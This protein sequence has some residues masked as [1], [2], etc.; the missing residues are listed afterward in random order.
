MCHFSTRL[1]DDV[2]IW[3]TLGFALVTVLPNIAMS[4]PPD[5]LR[6]RSRVAV[7]GR[8]AQ[9][10]Y[11][12]V[13]RGREAPCGGKVSAFLQVPGGFRIVRFP[14]Q[15]TAVVAAA[16][17]DVFEAASQWPPVGARRSVGFRST[18]QNERGWHEPRWQACGLHSVAIMLLFGAPE[19]QLSKILRSGQRPNRQGGL[20]SP[21]FLDAAGN[22]RGGCV[23][24]IEEHRLITLADRCSG[25]PA[26]APVV[27]RRQERSRN[28]LS[29]TLIAGPLPSRC[30]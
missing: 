17:G 3:L 30:G 5:C 23:D 25:Q 27:V 29:L 24:R 6:S 8:L 20:R 21:R 18:E 10:V 15:S 12:D 9:R 2:V 28:V 16:P 1:A 11:L 4:V 13:M 22:R 14:D 26:P 19:R 7:A